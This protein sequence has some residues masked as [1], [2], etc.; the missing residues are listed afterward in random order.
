VVDPTPLLK[1]FGAAADVVG[2]IATD[3]AINGRRKSPTTSKLDAEAEERATVEAG[4]LKISDGELL[5]DV[6]LTDGGGT[7]SIPHTLG[8]RA[9][10]AVVTKN[11]STNAVY[12]GAVVEDTEVLM[13]FNG[14]MLVDIWV[15]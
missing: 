13:R 1:G 10:G 12:C 8:R 5:E 11:S 7:Q 14:T 2:Q 3:K 15:F 6:A 4:R 9:I